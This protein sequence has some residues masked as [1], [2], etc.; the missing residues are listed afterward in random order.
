MHPLPMKSNTISQNHLVIFANT[1]TS[2]NT[3]YLA[4][5][6][7]FFSIYL[8]NDIIN[9]LN[10]HD[11]LTIIGVANKLHSFNTFYAEQSETVE[12]NQLHAATADNKRHFARFLDTLNKTK[13]ITNH[14]L[15]FEYSFQ[16]IEQILSEDK[17]KCNSN[18]RDTNVSPILMLYIS[19]GLLSEMTEAKIVLE[20]IASGQSR[21]QK[22][23]IIHTCAIILGN[24][25]N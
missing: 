8:A 15:A 22:P 14:T 5:F 20:T 7:N 19:R 2:L 13:E 23:V 12:K 3:N 21:L 1:T 18:E 9:L 11:Q 25:Q 24:L 6:I 10:G 17:F 16:L 4:K